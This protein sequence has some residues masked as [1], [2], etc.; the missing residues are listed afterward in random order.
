LF[1][2]IVS[3]IDYRKLKISEI[4][5]LKDIIT[6]N[7]KRSKVSEDTYNEVLRELDRKKI[8]AIKD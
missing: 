8:T 2:N 7:Y 5:Q 6:K 3:Q 4:D 1:H